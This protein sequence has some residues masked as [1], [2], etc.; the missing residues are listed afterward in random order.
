M[1]TA[2]L[3]GTNEV[4]MNAPDGSLTTTAGRAV[5]I[6]RREPDGEWR[7][8]L[9]IWNAA[10]RCGSLTQSWGLILQFLLPLPKNRRTQDDPNQRTA[11]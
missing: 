6:W 4:K 5:T 11:E 2:Y 9:D 3:M 10:I 7:C 1:D 8:V